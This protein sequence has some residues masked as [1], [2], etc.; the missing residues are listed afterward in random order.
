[1]RTRRKLMKDGSPWTWARRT[2]RV[3]S[4]VWTVGWPRTRTTRALL[5]A[6]QVYLAAGDQGRAEGAWKKL[7]KQ[8]R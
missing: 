1:M 4:S 2:S 8:S 7:L 5:V 6:G 3:H